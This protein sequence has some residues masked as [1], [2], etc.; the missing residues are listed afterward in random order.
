MSSK[1]IV[2]GIII[3]LGVC[4]YAT[5]MMFAP[6]PEKVSNGDIPTDLDPIQIMDYSTKLQSITNGGITF[7]LNAKAR[8]HIAGVVECTKDYH[9]DTVSLI[10]PMD[11]AICWGDVPVMAKYMKFSQYGR[12]ANYTYDL[13]SPVD[14]KYV[15]SHMSNN[16]LIPA[17]SNIRRSLGYAKKGNKVIVD[18]FLVNVTG[19]KPGRGTFHWNTSL[20]REDY[21]DG[22]CEIIYVTKLRINDKVYE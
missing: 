10:S 1:V 4:A 2:I 11:Y 14:P 21:G 20:K 9:K 19:S 16:H 7:D 15:V 3:F 22:A 13:N 17:N 12:F 18:G 6:I 5:Y 8:Y